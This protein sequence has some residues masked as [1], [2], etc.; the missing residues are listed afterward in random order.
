MINLR[1]ISLLWLGSDVGAGRRAIIWYCG[2]F[3]LLGKDAEL[4]LE[5]WTQIPAELRAVVNLPGAP[6]V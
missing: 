1:P 2:E 4:G 3:S 6:L 5:R